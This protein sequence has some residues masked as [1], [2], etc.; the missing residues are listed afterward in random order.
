MPRESRYDASRH[1]VLQVIQAKMLSH[2]QPPSV[3]ELAEAAD[4]GVAT[5]HDYLVK[6]NEEGLIEWQ[7]GRHRSLRCTPAGS[8]LL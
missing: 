4:V 6:L 7:R 2:G 1:K 5:M 3:R 8:R